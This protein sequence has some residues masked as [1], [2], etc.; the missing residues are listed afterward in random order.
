MKSLRLIALSFVVCAILLFSEATG[1]C[2]SEIRLKPVS[3]PKFCENAIAYEIHYF[4]TIEG[5]RLQVFPT[6][7]ERHQDADLI[8]AEV[9]RQVLTDAY[10]A[11]GRWMD[12]WWVEP[13]STGQINYLVGHDFLNQAWQEDNRR[14]LMR[15]ISS[16]AKFTQFHKLNVILDYKQGKM[17]NT[18]VEINPVLLHLEPT[19]NGPDKAVVLLIP[20]SEEYPPPPFPEDDPEVIL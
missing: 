19:Q 10:E 18:S 4:T 8:L 11:H 2:F 12:E 1:E 20:V 9:V 5:H 6:L 13:V 15:Y 17:V 7:A 16:K 3:V 14:H